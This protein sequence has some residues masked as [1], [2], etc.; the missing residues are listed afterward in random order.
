MVRAYAPTLHPRRDNNSVLHVRRLAADKGCPG[1]EVVRLDASV[2][3]KL[4]RHQ[5]EP[6]RYILVH[7]V[8]IGDSRLR[9]RLCPENPVRQSPVG[10]RN[11]HK[12]ALLDIL[13][14]V[15]HRRAAL[16]MAGMADD[17]RRSTARIARRRSL[18]PPVGPREIIPRGFGWI[19]A[20][21]ACRIVAC[22]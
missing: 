16:R 12:R 9:I 5:Y 6:I 2:T 10:G 3:P 21:H 17:E 4:A 11:G 18:V 14:S 1:N 15:E 19:E 8:D 22:R 13:Q 20:V 7:F